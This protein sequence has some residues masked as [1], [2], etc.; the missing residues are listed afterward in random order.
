MLNTKIQN[1]PLAAMVITLF[2]VSVYCELMLFVSLNDGQAEKILA[3]AFAIALVLGQLVQA[4]QAVKAWTAGNKTAALIAAGVVVLLMAISV[5]GTAIY[6]D[7]AYSNKS[8][9]EQQSGTAYQLLLENINQLKA[10]AAELK[11]TAQQEK[12]NGNAWSAGNREE[13][14]AEIEQ[15]LPALIAQLATLPSDASGS[16]TH[17]AGQISSGQRW[18]VWIV[19]ALIADLLPVLGVMQLRSQSGNTQ[20]TDNTQHIDSKPTR[21][22]EKTNT[23][24]TTQTPA[25]KQGSTNTDNTT[26][27][28]TLASTG[29]AAEWVKAQLL[30]NRK[31]PSAAEAAAAGIG[32][33]RWRNALAEL[34]QQGWTQKNPNGR[35]YVV[36][37]NFYETNSESKNDA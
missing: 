5:A 7:N 34:A 27:S 35:G 31:V 26:G 1:L 8:N 4:D 11:T 25:T 29:S 6:W 37:P 9:T 18:T 32:S 14:A 17:G 3:G 30:Q 16:A 21:A 24:N 19:L 15:Q 2:A 13:K 10:S 28:T 12:A 22:T 23:A 36:G 20:H 33:T